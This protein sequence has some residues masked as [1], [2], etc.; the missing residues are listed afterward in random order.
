VYVQRL[1][2]GGQLW[3]S[4]FYAEDTGVLL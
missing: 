2:E 3:L 1:K 4:G